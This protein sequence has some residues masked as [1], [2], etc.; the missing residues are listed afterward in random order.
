MTF[1][2]GVGFLIPKMEMG[3]WLDEIV[4]EAYLL[5]EGVL[6]EEYALLM[7]LWSL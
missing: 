6:P 5:D 4:G 1:N 2:K 7:L 3:G